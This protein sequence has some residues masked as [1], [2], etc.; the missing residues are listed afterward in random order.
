MLLFYIRYALRSIKRNRMSSA[1]NIAGLAIGMCVFLLCL[2]YYSYEKGFNRFNTNLPNLYRVN[3]A[4][5]DGKSATTFAPIAPIMEKNIP[6]VKAAMRFADNFN[7]GAV[8]SYN[9]GKDGTTIKSFS[10]DGCVF[11]DPSFLTSFSFPFVAGNSELDNPGTIVITAPVAKKFFGNEQNA[12]G[13]VLQLH[14]QFGN[15]PLTVTGVL[16]DIPAQSDIQFKYLLPINILKD[17]AYTEGSDW[18]KIDNWGNDSYTTYV[19]LDNNADP[20]VVASKA[21][22]LWKQSSPNYKAENG[23][24]QLQPLSEVHLGT[25]LKD[26]NPTYASMAMTY[27][28]FGLG[29]LILCIAWINYI[30]FSTAYAVGQAKQIGIHKIVGSDKKNIVIRYLT[31]SIILNLSGLLLAFCLTGITQSL[32]NYLTAKPLSLHYINNAGTWLSSIFIVLAG[33]VLCGGYVGFILAKFKPIAIMRLNNAGGNGNI[34]LRKGLVIFQFVISGVFIASTLIAYRQI[35]F[36]RHHNLGMNIDNL[37]VIDGPVIRDS[38]FKNNKVIFKNELARLPFVEKISLTGSV[39]G[40]GYAHNFGADGITGS[41]AQKGD[42]HKTYFISEID[43]SYFNTYQIPLLYGNNFSSADADK[44]FKGDRL[45]VNET[46]ARELGYE[47]SAATG[48]LINWGKS[49]IIAG[50]VKDY[51]HRSLKEKIEPIV[52]V[53]QHNNS[54]YTIKT[55]LDGLQQK[56]ARVRTVYEKLYPGNPFSYRVLRGTYN[57]LYADEERAGTV[58]LSISALVIIIACLGLVGLSVF[59][60][61]RRLKEM[62]IRKVLG[63]SAYSLFMQLSKDFLWLVFIAFIIASPVAWTLMDRWLQTFAYRTVITW[64]VFAITGLAIVFIALLT[65]SFQAVKTAVINPVKS[66]RT[67]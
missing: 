49:Y 9:P 24:I 18:A 44:S 22:A 63:A 60:A 50:I 23:T 35:N 52:Y 58:A 42:E 34:F 65:V 12:I 41:N 30:N 36:L 62:G 20:Q 61:K 3:I 8:V 27:F 48:K 2:E 39:P 67:E 14:N 15:L 31:E 51:N 38:T 1:L 4:A 32:F 47:P 57:S 16:A 59:T 10:E 17:P 6:G 40:S 46:A 54:C 37:V 25:S 29:I 21:S 28:I 19:R 53:P 13:K 45:I 66:L 55:N 5:R 33:I 43:E 7:D 64:G 11:A 56:M 26:D